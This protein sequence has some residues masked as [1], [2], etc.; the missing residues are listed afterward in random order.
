MCE[1][2]WIDILPIKASTLDK[3]KELPYIHR[4]PFDRYI[5]ATAL[6]ENRTIITRDSIIPQ[7]DVPTLW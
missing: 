7:Y 1:K 5:I 2:E 6:D 3:L 4:D